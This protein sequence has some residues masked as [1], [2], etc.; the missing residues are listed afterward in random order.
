MQ[1]CRQA[2]DLLEWHECGKA[3]GESSRTPHARQLATSPDLAYF[4]SNNNHHEAYS[5]AFELVRE[6]LSASSYLN[7]PR[8]YTNDDDSYIFAPA[9]PAG[10]R[11]LVVHRNSGDI[12]LDRES[13]IHVF[14][15]WRVIVELDSTQLCDTLLRKTI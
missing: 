15:S 6:H 14:E 12:V 2:F 13:P 10:A 11:P 3:R 4:L 5:R 1:I 8:R 9:E 7:K